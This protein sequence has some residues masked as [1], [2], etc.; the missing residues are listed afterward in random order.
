MNVIPRP[1]SDANYTAICSFCEEPYKY[2]GKIKI[3]IQS[4]KK[5]TVFICNN[6]LK[7]AKELL[8]EIFKDESPK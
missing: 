7:T 3:L 4:K 1:R 2:E 5:E 6:C 8:V